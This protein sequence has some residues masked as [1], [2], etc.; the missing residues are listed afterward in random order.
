MSNDKLDTLSQ[1]LARL[2][3]KL[4]RYFLRRGIS[5]FEAEDMVQETLFRFIRAGYDPAASDAAPKLFRIAKNQW[6]DS[7]RAKKAGRAGAHHQN[8]V[9]VDDVSDNLVDPIPLA[10]VRMMDRQ[11][12]EVVLH[13]IEHLPKN[14]RV[15]FELSRFDSLSHAEIAARMMISKSGVEKHISEALRRISRALQEGLQ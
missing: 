6:V 14:C 15:A 13:T 2:R 12:L 11:E 1:L 8:A 7:L 5:S 4:L 10:D 3:P 9:L